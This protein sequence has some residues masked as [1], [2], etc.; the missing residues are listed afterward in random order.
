MPEHGPFRSQFTRREVLRSMQYAPVLFLPA[1]LRAFAGRVEQQ[2]FDPLAIRDT[3]IT[4]HY[5]A[6]SPLDEMF[7]LVAP[8]RDQYATE[9]YAF[10]ITQTLQRWSEALT[11]GS[12]TDVLPNLLH[13]SLKAGSPLTTTERRISGRYG[14]T[15][16]RQRCSMDLRLGRQQFIDD[17]R[18]YLGTLARISTSEF[19]IT[20]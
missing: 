7:G 2:N 13:A 5:P 6:G 14:V 11:S 19:Q 10:E 17:V 12:T 3:A 1:P 16:F 9:K 4:P 15:V 20:S 18:Q 8:G